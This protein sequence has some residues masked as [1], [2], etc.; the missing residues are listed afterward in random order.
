MFTERLEHTIELAE[1]YIPRIVDNWAILEGNDDNRDHPLDVY[2][3]ICPELKYS[4]SDFILTAEAL[5]HNGQPIR[6]VNFSDMEK[7]YPLRF[8]FWMM[9]TAVRSVCPQYIIESPVSKSAIAKC[10]LYILKRRLRNKK[11]QMLLARDCFDFIQNF[12]DHNQRI[13]P[14]A[15]PQFSATFNALMVANTGS[16]CRFTNRPTAL[17]GDTHRQFLVP[18]IFFEQLYVQLET[19]DYLTAMAGL[20]KTYA[21]DIIRLTTSYLDCAIKAKK[22]MLNADYRTAFLIDN[23]AVILR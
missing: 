14:L 12:W 1:T 11:S 23:N 3:A 20:V 2:V 15:G 7:P 5:Y 16:V 17:I 21:P 9:Y 22:D 8:D 6:R 19:M 13:M 10:A 18:A 4:A